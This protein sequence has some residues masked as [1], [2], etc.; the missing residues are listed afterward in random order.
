MSENK[1]EFGEAMK[2]IINDPR[3]GAKFLTIIADVKD[4][5]NAVSEKLKSP[6]MQEQL[7]KMKSSL[8]FNETE[9]L[10]KCHGC[11]GKGWFQVGAGVDV[12]ATICPICKGTGKKI[13]CRAD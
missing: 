7:H 13:E 1:N 12:R 3:L 2:Q 9:A 6:E 5:G 11:Q 8:G 10:D 4:L